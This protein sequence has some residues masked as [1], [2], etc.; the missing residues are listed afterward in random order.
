MG[1]AKREGGSRSENFVGGLRGE[2][3][4]LRMRKIERSKERWRPHSTVWFIY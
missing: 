4:D 3:K 1:D 2:E